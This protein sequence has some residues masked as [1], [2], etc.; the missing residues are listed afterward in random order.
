MVEPRGVLTG[1][2]VGVAIAVFAGVTVGVFE[3]VSVGVLVDGFVGVLVG[4]FAGILVAVLV[5]VLV[6]VSVGVF[7]GVF[8]GVLVEVLVGVGVKAPPKSTINWGA[9]APDSRPAR[10][11]AVEP[12]VVIPKLNVPFPFT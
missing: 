9:L 4:V 12:G 7:E 3:G 11:M 1:V 10:L 2:D 8:V 6:G 5:D